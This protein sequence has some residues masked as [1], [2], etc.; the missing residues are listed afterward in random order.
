MQTCLIQKKKLHQRVFCNEIGRL[1]N[2]TFKQLAVRI[3]TL[4]RKSYSLNTY[5]FKNTKMTEIL[6]MTITPQL[7]KI[8]IK[9]EHHIL[10]QSE[11]QI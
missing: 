2:D 1:P 11:N 9:K 4:V 3:E 10:P 6:M 7:Q 8:A 5:D